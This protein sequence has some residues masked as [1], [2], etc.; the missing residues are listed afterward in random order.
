MASES[1]DRGRVRPAHR[2]DNHA[3]DPVSIPPDNFVSAVGGGEGSLPL[4]RDIPASVS[5]SLAPARSYRP[6][7]RRTWRDQVAFESRRRCA[8]APLRRPRA[9]SNV[10]V[11]TRNERAGR[12]PRAQ[13]RRTRRL[14]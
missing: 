1:R 8:V 11:R 5:V 12:D 9:N 3:N 6:W 10:V 13:P 4:E 14:L 7:S 2:T